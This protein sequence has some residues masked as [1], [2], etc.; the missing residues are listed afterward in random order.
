MAMFFNLLF[1]FVI[2]WFYPNAWHPH[3][4]GSPCHN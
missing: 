2:Q 3:W 1:H 4:S